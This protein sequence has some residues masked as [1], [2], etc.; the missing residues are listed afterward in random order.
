MTTSYM[1]LAGCE[2]KVTLGLNKAMTSFN[3][4]VILFLLKIKIFA[5][6]ILKVL[7]RHDASVGHAEGS[8]KGIEMIKGF[9]FCKYVF[10]DKTTTTIFHIHDNLILP[11][12]PH[13]SGESSIAKA[14]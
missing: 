7:F 5:W 8:N 3:W 6:I 10:P 13:M 4:V 14:L 2:E 9:H 1:S 11:S 12:F